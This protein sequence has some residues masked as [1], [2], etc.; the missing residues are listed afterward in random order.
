MG[1][2]FRNLM[3]NA[4]K[5]RHDRIEIDIGKDGDFF[6]ISVQ[7]DGEGIK[8]IYHDK[9]FESY[10]Q[11]EDEREH[12]VRGHGLG[13]A[14]ALILVEDMGGEMYLESDEGKGA[15]FFVRIPLAEQ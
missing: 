5:Y 12:C 7:D 15:K 8:E 1:Q 13:L 6:I 14:G 10:F 9:I 11:L 2:V 4:L 3:S